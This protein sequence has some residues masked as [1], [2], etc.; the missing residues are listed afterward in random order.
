M[1]C[2]CACRG[3]RRRRTGVFHVKRDVHLRPGE[4][5]SRRAL[6]S[7]ITLVA[8]VALIAPA[9]AIPEV[10]PGD[11]T[12][13]GKLLIAT[14]AI[15]D[16]RFVNTVILMVRHSKSGAM[17]LTINRPIGQRPLAN[18]LQATDHDTSGAAGQITIFAG[19]PVQP[20]AG[21]ILHD[22]SYRRADTI[23]IDGRVAMTSSPEIL[24]DIGGHAGP[25][26]FLVASAMLAGDLIKS[27]KKWP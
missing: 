2:S 20:E 10:A 27:K 21:F 5:I 17:G 15:G 14:P 16:P 19:G 6:V 18:L 3:L 4:P 23:D 11:A 24:G 7:L 25:L 22:T 26:K 8:P 1:G 12:L 9:S 13:V